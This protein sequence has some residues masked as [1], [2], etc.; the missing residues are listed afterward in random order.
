[1]CYIPKYTMIK[2]ICPHI[3]LACPKLRFLSFYLQDILNFYLKAFFILIQLHLSWLFVPHIK[4]FGNCD[5]L[6]SSSHRLYLL[7]AWDLVLSCLVS[8]YFPV[9]T[10]HLACWYRCKNC[11]SSKFIMFIFSGAVFVLSLLV[12]PAISLI[13]LFWKIISPFSIDCGKAWQ[14]RKCLHSPLVG[15]SSL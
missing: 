14:C 8:S 7:S 5:F 6:G 15:E 2:S 1:M 3:S 9:V 10:I 11:L 12:S 4:E 13:A